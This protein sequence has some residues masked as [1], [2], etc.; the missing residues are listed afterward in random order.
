M[1][2]L[3]ITPG[4]L[5]RGRPKSMVMVGLV[6]DIINFVVEGGGGGFGAIFG[7]EGKLQPGLWSQNI[8]QQHLYSLAKN[9]YHTLQRHYVLPLACPRSIHHI[10]RPPVTPPPPQS[11][12]L[13]SV[14]ILDT[15]RLLR[16]GDEARSQCRILQEWSKKYS[17]ACGVALGYAL[18]QNLAFGDLSDGRFGSACQGL[19]DEG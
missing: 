5:W 18:G 8:T 15:L 19:Q 14:L 2:D 10:P 3:E 4:W 9:G 11:Q 17:L 7:R 16:I 12:P 1:L 6:W 13:H